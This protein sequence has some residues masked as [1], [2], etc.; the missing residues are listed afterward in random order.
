MAGDFEANLES[1]LLFSG[2]LPSQPLSKSLVGGWQ[3]S[4]GHDEVFSEEVDD[5]DAPF[6]GMASGD[7]DGGVD[8]VIS[9]IGEL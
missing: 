2:G 7:V 9:R 1:K 3:S 6:V 5:D 8:T 4:H